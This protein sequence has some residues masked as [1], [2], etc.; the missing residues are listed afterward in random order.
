MGI[1]RI[2][3]KAF[4]SARNIARGR[5]KA[6]SQSAAQHSLGILPITS[7]PKPAAA[8]RF[9]SFQPARQKSG[10]ARGISKPCRARRKIFSMGGKKRLAMR[11]RIVSYKRFKILWRVPIV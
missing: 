7:E 5:E 9:P 1:D 4:S 8:R 3:H 2:F 11:K 10:F 6:R